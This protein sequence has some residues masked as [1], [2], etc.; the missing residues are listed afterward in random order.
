ML[1]IKLYIKKNSFVKNLTWVKS[2]ELNRQFKSI[3]IL[4]L[5]N[6]L[7]YDEFDKQNDSL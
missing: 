5:E 1:K 3:Q 4:Y 6:I 7:A 2:K